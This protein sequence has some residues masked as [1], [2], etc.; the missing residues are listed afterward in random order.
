M[1]K[2]RML[3][4]MV[5]GLFFP[6]Q[7]ML[8]KADIQP[9]MKSEEVSFVEVNRSNG[10]TRVFKENDGY[11]EVIIRKVMNWINTASS[12]DNAKI[13]VINETP[14]VAKMKIKMK[15]GDV[16]VIEPAYHCKPE[17][18]ETTKCTIA[19][20]EVILTQNDKTFRLKSLEL[21]DWLLVGWKYESVGAP[22]DE[23]LEETLY[24]RYFSYLDET[25]ADFISCPKIDQVER[26]DG[27]KSRHLIHASALNYSSHHGEVPY[28]KI[29]ITLTDTQEDGVKLQK[30]WIEK[31]ISD[32]DSLIQ[33][34]RES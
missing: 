23:L 26:I 20:G 15:N 12:S 28:D 11:E 14:E 31:S 30:V 21:Y 7:W 2:I 25:Y 9:I 29:H 18:Q 4:M 34:R 27:S 13:P 5:V 8:V 33:C 6:V 16:A 32:K 1:K 10:E 17:K 19:D 24:R 3:F 22:K